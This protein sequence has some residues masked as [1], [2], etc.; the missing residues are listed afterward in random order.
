MEE[1]LGCLYEMTAIDL[2]IPEHSYSITIGYDVSWK[3]NIE[4]H[5]PR[6]HEGLDK[7][8]SFMCGEKGDKFIEQAILSAGP[9]EKWLLVF[10]Y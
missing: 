6:A 1:N 4:R 3:I 5:D 2:K 7:L 10:H 8:H 9:F